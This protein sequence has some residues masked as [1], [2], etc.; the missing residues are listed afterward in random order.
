[1]NDSHGAW[2]L[3][4][5]LSLTDVW[6][7]HTSFTPNHGRAA[8]P[9]GKSSHTWSQAGSS[10][11]SGAGREGAGNLTEHELQP[12]HELSPADLLSFSYVSLVA[13]RPCKPW[14]FLSLPTDCQP[15]ASYL[16]QAVRTE[17]RMP[18]FS[19]YKCHVMYS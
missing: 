10:N 19:L 6:A 8:T 1:M 11:S 4:V 15:R 18:K 12:R 3:G 16:M 7:L 17:Q 2:A 14:K 9:V 5:F 13:E